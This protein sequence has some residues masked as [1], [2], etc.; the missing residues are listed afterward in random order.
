MHG[1]NRNGNSS[2]PICKAKWTGF[3]CHIQMISI[4]VTTNRIGGF[5]VLTESLKKQT[6]K[7]FELI[8]VDCLYDYRRQ[9]VK[10]K[11]LEYDFLITHIPP[12]NNRF[13]LNI[14][15]HCSNSAFSYV[16]GDIVLF[17][18]DYSWFPENCLQIHADHFEKYGHNSGLICP[19]DY[20]SLPEFKSNFSPY[21]NYNY[22]APVEFRDTMESYRKNDEELEKYINDLKSG[23]LNNC[24][25]SIFKEDLKSIEGLSSEGMSGTDVRL[26]LPVGPID[27][28][29][30]VNRNDSCAFEKVLQINGYDEDFDEA[31]CFQDSEFT[32]RLD[33]SWELNPSNVIQIINPR[34]IFPHGKRI[35]LATTNGDLLEKKRFAGFPKVNNWS[36]RDTNLNIKKFKSQNQQ[37]WNFIPSKISEKETKKFVCAWF[38]SMKINEK[39]KSIL[40]TIDNKFILTIIGNKNIDNVIHYEKMMRNQ[41]FVSD[42]FVVFDEPWVVTFGKSDYKVLFIT[43]IN[44]HIFRFSIL[45]NEIICYTEEIYFKL[46]D[47]IKNTKLSLFEGEL[48]W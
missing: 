4:I 21:I 24:M 14:C 40:E 28:T 11:F 27:K 46:K 31:H 9:F 25:W 26:K 47:S 13:P 41:A 34:S 20:K 1:Y 5:D 18:T 33:V 45:Y 32:A 10:E 44:E 3:P 6:Y 29:F 23:K 35:R 15:N 12:F 38:G 36:I 16:N 43:E 37:V 8:I 39:Y 2:L 19:H 30:F 7:N 17:V 22:N 42:I 48:S